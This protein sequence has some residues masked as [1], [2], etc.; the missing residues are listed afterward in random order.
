VSDFDPRDVCAAIAPLLGETRTAKLDAVAAGR[1]AGVAAV[2]EDIRDPHNAGAVLRSCE[3]MG[4]LGV[5][6]IS[7][8]Q[9][10]RTSMR[11]TQGS[12]KWLELSRHASAKAC[13]DALHAAGYALYAAVPGGALTV[14]EIDPLQKSALIFGNEHLGLSPEL[15]A[16]SDGEFRIPMFGFS[17]SLNVSVSAAIS[18]SALCA[19]RRRAIGRDGDLEVDQ[20]NALRARYYARDIRGWEAIVER[21]VRER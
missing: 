18:L 3:A 13:A 12:E 16:L 15:R 10:F 17:Q 1:L 9:R 19:A 2:L 8:R 14:G 20:L 11:V 6:L 7:V 4:V 21:F 5:H